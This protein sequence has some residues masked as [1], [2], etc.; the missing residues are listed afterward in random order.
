MH[1]LKR[2]NGLPFLALCCAL[3]Q[4]G[5]TVVADD[6]T[7]E[8]ICQIPAIKLL[9]TLDEATEVQFHK[10][11]FSEAIRFLRDF[12]QINL[13][14]DPRVYREADLK[15]DEHVTAELKGVP[16]RTALKLILDPLD[17]GFIAFDD[18]L[19][20]TTQ[21]RC[22]IERQLRVYPVSDLAQ[23]PDELDQLASDIEGCLTPDSDNSSPIP[24]VQSVTSA[25]ALVVNHNQAGQMQVLGLLRDLRKAK[26]L[27]AP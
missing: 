18:M 17:L 11:E 13:V 25:H 26:K 2:V 15:P 9:R 27:A 23:T 16:L 1:C 24:T 10:V 5:G 6:R 22:Q 3:M 7:V 20:V 19:L 21:E 14:I 12:H 8:V 4:V